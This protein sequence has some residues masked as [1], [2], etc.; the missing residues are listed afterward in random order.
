MI[1]LIFY[2]I[3]TDRIRTKIAR[4]L[5]AEG[6]ERIQLSVFAGNPHP[7]SNTQLWQDLR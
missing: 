5:V 6:Y 4:R 7:Q 2:D 1:H 3:S